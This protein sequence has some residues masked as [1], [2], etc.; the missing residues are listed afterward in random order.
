MVKINGK[1]VDYVYPYDTRNTIAVKYGGR[2]NIPDLY[3]RCT[4]EGDIQNA[5]DIN[6]EYLVETLKN[7]KSLGEA[8]I[9]YYPLYDLSAPEFT[10]VYI[11]AKGIEDDTK[12]R[13]LT[14]ILR[15]MDI[16]ASVDTIKNIYNRF[17]VRVKETMEKMEKIQSIQDNL[18]D[19]QPCE[20]GQFYE[21]KETRR[22]KFVTKVKRSI[23]FI[24][25]NLDTSDSIPIV[26]MIYKGYNK[27]VKVHRN[28]DYS[29]EWYNQVISGDEQG[30]FFPIIIQD[31]VLFAHLTAEMY[32]YIDS[33]SY[34]HKDSIE[35]V[36]VEGFLPRTKSIMDNDYKKYMRVNFEL[37]DDSSSKKKGKF[38]LMCSKLEKYI[39]MDMVTNDELFNYFFYAK[40]TEQL[41]L[42]K[43]GLDTKYKVHGDYTK[44]INNTIIDR[45]T[46]LEINCMTPSSEGDLYDVRNMFRYLYAY[47]LIHKDEVE[48]IYSTYIKLSSIP[49]LEK[50]SVEEEG[51]KKS[52]RRLIELQDK[53]PQLYPPNFYGQFCESKPRIVTLEEKEEMKK[54]L[55]SDNFFKRYGDTAE[56]KIEHL[57]VTHHD[58]ILDVD[59]IYTCYPENEADEEYIGDRIWPGMKQVKKGKH[60]D[61]NVDWLPCCYPEDQYEKKTGLN[62]YIN[63]KT[64]VVENKTTVVKFDKLVLHDRIGYTPYNI[65]R[66]FEL[67]GFNGDTILRHGIIPSL[68]SFFHCLESIFNPK[69]A[70]A[71][72]DKKRVYVKRARKAISNMDYSVA[73]QS[74]FDVKDS[75]I[76]KI[77]LSDHI[78][79]D[80]SRFVRLAEIYYDCAIFLYKFS[81]KYNPKGEIL[82]PYHHAPYIHPVKN[83]E[84]SVHIIAQEL[85]SFMNCCYLHDIKNKKEPGIFRDSNLF[86]ICEESIYRAS[87]QFQIYV[88]GDKQVHLRDTR[89]LMKCL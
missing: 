84:R 1:K 6:L 78:P 7:S 5:K 10:S 63:K 79:I 55:L 50:E 70:K 42:N 25:D 14:K 80:P 89:T 60:E 32:L 3:I 68:D 44:S 43:R 72:V 26:V 2:N 20:A 46:Y 21:V 75:M 29:S 56:E 58:P 4:N 82:L 74:L 76:R 53:K 8:F 13:S 62:K 49:K 22:V 45:D 65:R 19:V 85:G 71:S 18:L 86:R 41:N 83:N 66:L 59:D 67:S 48:E 73:K 69:Y 12:I 31:I 51:N 23:P 16:N 57:F 54:M 30:L 87:S 61:E 52:S 37:S 15:N 36:I 38:K 28:S 81:K 47:Y 24:F 33:D 11:R 17:N 64:K 9:D 39:F 34:V 77:L 27:V 40:E 35:D 88:D